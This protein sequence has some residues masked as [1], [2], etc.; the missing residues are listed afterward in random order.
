MTNSLSNTDGMAIPLQLQEIG[1]VWG[2][3]RPLVKSGIDC[4]RIKL[5][6]HKQNTTLLHNLS[7]IAFQSRVAAASNSG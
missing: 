7:V 3:D 2:N 1:Q 4:L 5:G 6:G